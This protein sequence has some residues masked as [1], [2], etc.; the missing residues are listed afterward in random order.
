MADVNNN[1]NLALQVLF[2]SKK[3]EFMQP[4]E[5]YNV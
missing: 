4:G 2:K 3:F 5:R 1:G